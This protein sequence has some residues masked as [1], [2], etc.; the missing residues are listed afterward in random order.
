MSDLSAVGYALVRIKIDPANPPSS[1]DVVAYDQAVS[2]EPRFVTAAPS[3]GGGDPTWA[4]SPAYQFDV[5]NESPYNALSSVSGH[6]VLDTTRTDVLPSQVTV[7]VPPYAY[8]AG[9]ILD[10]VGAFLSGL[11]LVDDGLDVDVEV[12]VSDL[13]GSNVLAAA[14]GVVI[15]PQTDLGTFGTNDLGSGETTGDDLTLASGGITTAAG[16]VYVIVARLSIG[17]D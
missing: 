6:F 8:P 11:P 15:P 13:D 12:I 17:W 3:G 1:G 2:G 10:G 5:G 9:T 7:I 14:G 16:G 4:V